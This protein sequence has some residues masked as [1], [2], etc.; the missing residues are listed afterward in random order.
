MVPGAPCVD[1]TLLSLYPLSLQLQIQSWI[2]GNVSLC[3]RQLFIFD[4]IDKMPVGMID[5]IKPFIDYH[6][7]IMGVDYRYVSRPRFIP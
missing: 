5:G 2:Q 6:T 1:P 7:N 3:D 4:E